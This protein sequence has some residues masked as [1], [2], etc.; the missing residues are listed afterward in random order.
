L[1]KRRKSLTKTLDGLEDSLEDVIEADPA[2]RCLEEKQEKKAE[3]Q[4]RSNS[5]FAWHSFEKRT[6]EILHELHLVRKA[7][8]SVDD[9]RRFVLNTL[10]EGKAHVVKT[11][12]SK[13][14]YKVSL[15]GIDDV[16]RDYIADLPCFDSHGEG[17]ITFSLPKPDEIDYITLSKFAIDYADGVIAGSENIDQSLIDYAIEKGKLFLPYQPE[18][19]RNDAIDEFYEKVWNNNNQ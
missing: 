17:I 10:T 2:V 9:V 1:K 3:Q 7:V 5:M 18:D 16:M 15:S 11:D 4:K 19:T 13:D 14:H 12:E 6:G 8:G